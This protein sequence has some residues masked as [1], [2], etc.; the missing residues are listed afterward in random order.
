MDRRD[1]I[2][3]G[4][5][6]A[7]ATGS[8]ITFGNFSNIFPKS[9][10][11]QTTYDLVAVK[12]GEPDVMFNKAISSLGGMK[13]FIKKGQKVVVKPN[14][15]WDVNPE[16]AANTNP[17]LVS[18]IIKHC[19]EAGAKEVYV[20]DHT[21]DN[22]TRCYSNSGIERAAKDAG[23]KVVSGA[24]EGYYQDVKVDSGKNLSYAKVHELILDS[25]VFINVPVLKSHGGG[26][27]TASMKNLMGIVW[28]RGYWHQNNLHQCIAD[29]ATFK[30]PDLTIVDA[31]NVMMRNG[32]RGTSVNDLSLMKS[33]IISADMVAADSAAAKIFGINPD[34]V[35]YIKIADQ[36][37]AGT[38]DLTKLKI[39]R[40]II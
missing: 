19:F 7:I 35:Q 29:F 4:T 22:W 38:K 31:Y 8:A 26:R 33:L 24:S 9:L 27:I 16:R 40:I 11:S 37:K 32:P 21:C 18:I 39:N 13:S 2:K 23:A 15:G 14:I 34:D 17:K 3:K 30:K 12:G 25:D 36:M 5:F 10:Y 1:F 6:A 20:F 28:D